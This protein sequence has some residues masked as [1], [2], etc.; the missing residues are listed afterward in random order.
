MAY[1]HNLPQNILAVIAVK[2]TG[3]LKCCKA[4]LVPDIMILSGSFDPQGTHQP[5]LVPW[6]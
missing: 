6:Y 3:T 1:I 2:G 5:F 4:L